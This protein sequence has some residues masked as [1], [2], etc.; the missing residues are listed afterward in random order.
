MTE[1]FTTAWIAAAAIK[2][3]TGAI[4]A[5]AVRIGIQRVER[6]IQDGRTR[7]LLIE[8]VA[9]AIID[10][11]EASSAG[12]GRNDP[13]MPDRRVLVC[14]IR[15]LHEKVRP[16]LLG[17]GV[18]PVARPDPYGRSGR[19]LETGQSH[20]EDHWL[21]PIAVWLVTMLRGIDPSFTASP[22][23]PIRA[24][25]TVRGWS[26]RISAPVVNL[27]RRIRPTKDPPEEFNVCK[28]LAGAGVPMLPAR[29]PVERRALPAT[30]NADELAADDGDGTIICWVESVLDRILW[31]LVDDRRMDPLVRH[32]RSETE[33]RHR[34]TLVRQ[35]AA[36]VT[37]LSLLSLA[38]VV[39]VIWL[40]AHG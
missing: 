22:S 21:Y 11:H 34:Q 36:A 19:D 3:A 26:G 28:Q 29:P 38:S 31:R 2:G 40:L 30:G 25:V 5:G 15:D 13:Q 16:A 17:H 37:A 18:E 6:Q 12:S 1:P 7:D 32:L 4:G 23:L 9:D 33:Q 10:V 39:A 27:Y 35:L 24:G 14:V 20:P 8:H